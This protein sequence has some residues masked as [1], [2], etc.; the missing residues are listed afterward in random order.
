MF[1]DA[2][3]NCEGPSFSSSSSIAPPF[4]Q[5]E[6][7]LDE[8][9]DENESCLSSSTLPILQQRELTPLERGMSSEH[10]NTT[11][12]TP[13]AHLR[14]FLT[15]LLL[16][17]S[18]ETTA[19]NIGLDTMCWHHFTGDVGLLVNV[20]T[21]TSAD[22]AKYETRVASG[23]QVSPTHRGDLPVVMRTTAGDNVCILFS[24]VL[25]ANNFDNLLSIGQLQAESAA[26]PQPTFDWKQEEGFLRFRFRGMTDSD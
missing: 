17:F 20:Q 14:S 19:V 6:L 22:F 3:I 18:V 4:L 13:M 16:S 10:G 5:H 26:A 7:V 15:L 2:D 23:S 1:N 24:D 9:E 8:E 21:L 25:Y 12:H 11:N